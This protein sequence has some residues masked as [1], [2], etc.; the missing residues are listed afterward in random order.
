MTIEDF[1]ELCKAMSCNMTSLTSGL[2]NF[3]Q[4]VGAG[5]V[6][7]DKYCI[8]GHRSERLSH[9][10]VSRASSRVT[11]GETVSVPRATAT[12][13]RVPFA[14]L[15]VDDDPGVTGTFARMLSLQ[16]YAVRTALTAEAGL[17]EAEVSR[18]DG[19]LLDMRMPLVDGL[20]FLKRLRAREEGRA[21]AVAVIT[22]DY[23]LDDM[24]LEELRGLGANV[25]FKPVWFD[26]LIRITEALVDVR[27]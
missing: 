16:G 7:D 12:S 4:G 18:P 5:N 19:I 15:I 6:G 21:T 23:F 17:R 1:R 10:S 27:R 8:A 11:P 2:V 22:G 25:H 14:I 20:A 3:K 26:D 13:S 24:V 9:M